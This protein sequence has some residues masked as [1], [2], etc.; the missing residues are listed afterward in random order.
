M[1]REEYDS[2]DFCPNYRVTPAGKIVPVLVDSLPAKLLSLSNTG[3]HTIRDN[4]IFGVD[5]QYAGE[6]DTWGMTY[7]DDTL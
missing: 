5:S 2:L 7:T 6:T 4:M 3:F 1:T